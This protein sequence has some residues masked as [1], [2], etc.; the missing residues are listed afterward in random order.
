VKKPLPYPSPNTA[1]QSYRP[2]RGNAVQD[3]KSLNKGIEM[4][5]DPRYD[6]L[7]EIPIEELDL[8]VKTIEILKSVGDVA[9][10]DCVD[11][12]VR[13]GDAMITVPF[14][15]LEAMDEEVKPKL[16]EHGYWPLDKIGS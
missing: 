11:H 13:A 9:V 10:G 3:L 2:G 6:Y 4:P 1:S 14:G 12:F 16:E 7:Y 8:S 5:S 15:L